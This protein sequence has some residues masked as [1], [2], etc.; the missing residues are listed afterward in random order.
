MTMSTTSITLTH[1]HNGTSTIRVDGL[2][3]DVCQE[4]GRSS[5]EAVRDL[6]D[7][8]AQA[9]AARGDGSQDPAP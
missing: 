6:A 9:L 1:G 8:I 2:V 3:I 5:P 7:W 4:A